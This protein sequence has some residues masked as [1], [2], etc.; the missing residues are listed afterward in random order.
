MTDLNR[1]HFL[2]AGAA[3]TAGAMLS[4]PAQAAAPKDP[5]PAKWDE[6][7]DVVVIGSGFAGLAAAIEAKAAGS[8]VAVLEKMPT[9]GGNSIING[10]ILSVPGNAPQ[11]ALGVKDSPQLLAEDIIRE[12][13]GLNYPEKV[14]LMAREAYPTWEWTVKTLGVE[15]MDKVGQEGGHSVPRFLYTKNGSGS[16]IVQKEVDYLAKQGSKSVP[17][18]TWRR[19]SATRTVA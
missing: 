6:T 10:G 12:G 4:G 2:A 7:Y 17:A 16:A 18:A 5:M 13:Q 9:Y 8:T 3:A 15:Y 1:R 19:S 14:K 11:K